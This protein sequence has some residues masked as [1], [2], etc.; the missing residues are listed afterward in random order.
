LAWVGE[1]VED[2]VTLTRSACLPEEDDRVSFGKEEVNAF[3]LLS[4][5]HVFLQIFL[6]LFCSL[7][8][9]FLGRTRGVVWKDLKTSFKTIFFNAMQKYRFH[10]N[11]K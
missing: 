6:N 9:F 11:S 3:R 7:A 5:F 2:G 10:F 4:L 1:K 8:T